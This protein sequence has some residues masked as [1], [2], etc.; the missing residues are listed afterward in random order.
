MKK[1]PKLLVLG[2]KLPGSRDGGGFVRDEI[3][4]DYPKDKYV[5]YAVDPYDPENSHDELPSSVR[6]VPFMIGQL[7]GEQ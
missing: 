6:N 1:Y 5:C 7:D 2:H 3:L 4:K